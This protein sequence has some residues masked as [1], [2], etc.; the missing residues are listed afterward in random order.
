MSVSSSSSSNDD[1]SNETISALKVPPFLPDQRVF[2]TDTSQP[3]TS[4][5]A[6]FEAVV[7][8]TSWTGQHWTFLVHYLGWNARWD[9]WLDE[10][11]VFADTPDVR[12]KAQAQNKRK[13]SLE[14][15]TSASTT[16][17]R[18]K[19]SVDRGPTFAEYCELPFT[20]KT[21]LVD[22]REKIMR[23]NENGFCVM[24]EKQWKPARLVHDLPAR[25][26]IRTVLDHFCKCK[27]KE[28]EE[29]EAKARA[30][31]QDFAQLFD[32]SLAKCLLY[33]PERA[34]YAAI[35]GNASKL[36]QKRNVEIY[37]CEFLLRFFVRLPILLE[38]TSGE[39][40]KELGTQ[41]A[42]LIVLLQKNR[43]ACFKARYREPQHEELQD[44]EKSLQDGAAPIAMDE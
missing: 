14:Q 43:Q 12:L 40:R 10:S 37:G 23:P 18:K 1:I 34:Q 39:N 29:A 28:S 15:E 13:R 21:I 33:P 11:H 8:K 2:C 7:R 20:L 4:D 3:N 24:E 38:E 30:F 31:V 19:R 27:K 22:D 35:Q 25:V 16:T 5:G 26:T 42:D 6:L 32:D 17:S 44:W 41:L 9:K 36:S